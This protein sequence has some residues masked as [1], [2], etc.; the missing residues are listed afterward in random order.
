MTPRMRRRLLRVGIV[1]LGLV[2][3]RFVVRWA[4]ATG[5]LPPTSGE[6]GI[7][8]LQLVL[9]VALVTGVVLLVRRLVQTRKNR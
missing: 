5:R 2:V 7:V 8:V 3:L 9:V 4:D 6:M 1:L